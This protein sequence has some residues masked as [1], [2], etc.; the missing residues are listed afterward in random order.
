MSIDVKPFLLFFASLATSSSSC[1][2]GFLTPSLHKRAA[3]LYSSHVTCPCFHCLCSSLLLFSLTS[4]S[5]I[6]HAGLFPS[7]PDILHLGTESSCA[8]WKPSLKICQLCSAPLL[9]RSVSQGGPDYTSFLSHIPQDCELH[10]CVITAAQAASN[11]DVTDELTC[12]GDHQVQ[13]CN[14][15]GREPMPAGSKTGQLLA[16]VKPIR[17]NGSTSGI[18]YSRRGKKTCTT[19]TAATEKSENM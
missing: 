16:K 9:L 11:L 17:D 13:Y 14:P 2:L 18:T 19:G 12:I 4:M 5:R 15:S 7:L 3:S 1:T 6:S 10:Q 8:L